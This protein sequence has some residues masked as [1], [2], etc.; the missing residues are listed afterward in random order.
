M[1]T[2]RKCSKSYNV[3]VVSNTLE[4][5]GHEA[6]ENFNLIFLNRIK[7]IIGA[8]TEQRKSELEK[9]KSDMYREQSGIK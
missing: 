7:K 6:D 2:R 1:E 9:L 5:C 3:P 4:K 8:L